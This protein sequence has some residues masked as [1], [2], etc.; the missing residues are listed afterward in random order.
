VSETAPPPPPSELPESHEALELLRP[1]QLPGSRLV[2]ES[3][4]E[5]RRAAGPYTAT[6]R[7]ALAQMVRSRAARFGALVL[8]SLA[9]VAIFADFLAS[10]LPIACHWRGRTYLLPNVTHPA[11]LTGIDCD[12][13]RAGRGPG[14]WYLPPLA[15]HGPNA[16]RG[17]SEALLPPLARG[18]ALGTDARGRDV[19]ARVVHGA[20]AALGIGLAGSLVLVAVGLTLGAI[21]GFAG[22]FIDGLVARLVESLTAIP[23]L[24]LV[25]VVG[26]LV[27]RASTATVVWTIALTRWTE[28]ARLVRADVLLTLGKD[29]VTAARALGASPS[30]V[31][32]RHVL[33]HAL[34]PAIVAAAFG[35]ASIILLEAS[36]DFLRLDLPETIVSWGETLGEAR[37]S[38]GA[39]WLIAFPGVAL[40]ATLTALNLVGEAARDAMD[41]FLDIDAH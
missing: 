14:D 16:T 2:R 20:R 19:F 31:L 35:V 33:P 17:R 11:T 26:A 10:D 40:L 36:V 39:W 21:A 28:L 9:L 25:L 12:G 15:T 34:G 38:T 24:L 6:T 18:H 32:R 13:M 5:A 4:V 23:T 1:K 41:P 3:L 30:R 22:G 29:Y 37:N 7:V 8:A 27:P